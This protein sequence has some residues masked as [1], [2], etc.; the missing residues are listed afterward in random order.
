MNYYKVLGIEENSTQEEIKEAYNRQ[1]ET[2][3]EEVKDEKRL[4]KFL[5]LFKEAYDALKYEESILQDQKEEIFDEEVSALFKNNKIEEKP[6]D[7]S[8]NKEEVKLENQNIEN[9]YAATVLMS[10]EEILKKSLIQHNEYEEGRAIF[11]SKEDFQECDGFFDDEDE[12]EDF[13]EKIIKK[14][15]KKNPYKNK[16]NS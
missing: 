12:E 3:K 13:E 11:K 4:E 10:R 9:S 6:V 14:I 2:F 16:K 5:D 15:K 1:V 8:V 7:I